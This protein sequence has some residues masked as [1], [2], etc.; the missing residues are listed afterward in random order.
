M[1]RPVSFVTK[2]LD[3]ACL[4]TLRPSWTDA[5]GRRGVFFFNA[6]ETT[7]LGECSGIIFPQIIFPCSSVDH[8][9]LVNLSGDVVVGSNPHVIMVL[10]IIIYTWHP[11]LSQPLYTPSARDNKRVSSVNFHM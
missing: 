8:I 4:V 2:A 11:L 6:L 3:A 9:N 7:P 1:I 5:G 10:N